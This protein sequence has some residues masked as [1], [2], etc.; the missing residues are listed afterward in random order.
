MPNIKTPQSVI[1]MLFEVANRFRLA[2]G[3]G[4]TM[5]YA[6][7]QIIFSSNNIEKNKLVY[8]NFINSIK[9]LESK[10]A[11]IIAISAANKMDC[12]SESK[13]PPELCDACILAQVEN[14]PILTEDYLYLQMNALETKKKMPEHFS[15]I[16]LMR[17]LY[18]L[19][20]IS[21]DDYLIYFG[22]LS[23]YRVRFLS[24]NSDDI[25]K[26]IF[27]ESKII[28]IVPENIRNLNFP[29]TLSEEYGV[30]FHSSF[31]V[32]LTFLFDIIIDDAITKDVAENIYAEILYLLPIDK[33]KRQ[34]GVMLLNVCNKKIKDH[35]SVIL[36]KT[37]EEKIY[38]LMELTHVF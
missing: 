26:A 24:L 5:G 37:I 34:F 12:L 18:E 6:R 10:N 33:N 1:K 8:N 30:S 14:I 19:G 27:G 2:Q 35:Y 29:L 20:K 7:G 15:T 38:S 9:I 17:V 21:F 4:G 32:L 28:K 11:N 16:S 36:S 31:N 13:V 25:K 3:E 22:Y 23:S